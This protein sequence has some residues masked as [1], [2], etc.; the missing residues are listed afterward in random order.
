MKNYLE[1]LPLKHVW[2][3][4]GG[5]SS[6]SGGGGTTTNTTTNQQL[7]WSGY[8]PPET[9]KA[10]QGIMPQLEAKS[11]VGLTP[12]EKSFYTGQGMS[13]VAKASGS[14]DKALAGNLAR[15]GARGGAVTEAYSDAARSKVLA[16]QGVTS[17]VQGLDVQ[18]KGANMD[19][20]MKAIAL[21]GSPITTGTSGVTQY[22][23]TKQSS[24]GS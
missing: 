21:P 2:L 23:P 20:L 7:P 22:S 15:S 10:Y 4:G 19:R 5:G 12:Q 16:N 14:A 6:G 17:N 1:V 24:G 18:Q 3:F 11:G 8:V 13:D 9:Y